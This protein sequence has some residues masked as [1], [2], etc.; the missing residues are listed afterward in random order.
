MDGSIKEGVSPISLLGRN[1]TVSTIPTES[2]NDEAI[3]Q[4]PISCSLANEEAL[5]ERQQQENDTRNRPNKKQ[6]TS[7]EP[8]DYT[9]AKTP[10][11]TS[12]YAQSTD[13]SNASNQLRPTTPLSSLPSRNAHTSDSVLSDV[14][15]TSA[16]SHR[17][18]SLS[19]QSEPYAAYLGPP[20]APPSTPSSIGCSLYN[21][22]DAGLA[23]PIPT[24]TSGRFINAFRLERQKYQQEPPY[25]CDGAET[26][27]PTNQ[28]PPTQLYESAS[29]YAAAAATPGAPTPGAATP[30]SNDGR[31]KSASNRFHTEDF[32]DWAVGDRYKLIRMLGRGS[33]GEVAQAL[34]LDARKNDAYVAI[35]R[36]QSPFDKEVDSVRLYREI[37]ILRRIRGHPCIIQLLDVVQPPTDDLDDF[38]DLYLVFECKTR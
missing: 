19:P 18:Y 3:S 24:L 30:H 2:T 38:H 13:T 35:K 25:D 22:I 1:E 10:D 6:R 23:T 4:T 31:K 5:D 15:S 34:D 32:S 28:S 12:D 36:I 27:A 33:Y 7:S 8:T 20:L 17:R 11:I 29:A 37:N 21:A 26:P 16:S 9:H 14:S